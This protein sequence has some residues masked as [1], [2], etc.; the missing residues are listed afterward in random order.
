M[1]VAPWEVIRELRFG[2]IGW[3]AGAG[4]V[5]G[6]SM[7]AC[8]L[9]LAAGQADSMGI[10]LHFPAEL[11]HRGTTIERHVGTAVI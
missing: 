10:D 2:L 8:P 3:D 9:L 5:F 7:Q 1:S 6:L 4:R 11:V